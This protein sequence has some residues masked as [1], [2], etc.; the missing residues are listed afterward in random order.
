MRILVVGGGI[1]G[2]GVA[3]AL[4]GRG[5][6]TLVEQEPTLAFHTTGRSAALFFENYGAPPIRPLSRASRTFLED[7]PP[8][9]VDHPL[10]SPRGAL[11][12]GS[13][14]DRVAL[15]LEFEDGFS[16]VSGVQ[17]LDGRG[18]RAICPALRPEA[19]TDAVW[20]PGAADI[21]VA[22]LHQA[23][24][25]LLRRGGGDVMLGAELRSG[26]H[27]AN[28]WRVELVDREG[29]GSTWE[30][31]VV[32]DAAGAWADVVAERCGIRPVGLQ[33]MRRTAFM[34]PGS[35]ASSA[36][37]LVAEVRHRWY[38]KPDGEQVLCSLADE[39]PSDPCD[40]RPEELDVA[41]A[42]DRINTATTLDI[43]HVR[44]SWAGLRTFAP[45]RSMVIGPDPEVPEFVW[46]AGQ[47]G[48]GI[49]TAP[50]A[51]RLA[52]A[53]ALGEA[54]PD[55]LLSTGCDVA[56]LSPQRFHSAA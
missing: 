14:D 17:R 32:V 19:V 36:W 22:G 50:A 6:V 44:S 31:E 29:M 55:D 26:A 16:G 12:V 38:F 8:G 5:D 11:I 41:L 46:L 56:A 4:A 47:G 30:G 9:S 13:D 21:D 51:G 7:P 2:A 3:A 35:A 48:T 43:R 52:A 54:I 24:V 25:R 33:P 34:V 27:G 18:A 15:D 1:A 23:F 42:I 39:T 10:L 20:E 40:A 49:Q 45:D 28:G 53:V 37:P